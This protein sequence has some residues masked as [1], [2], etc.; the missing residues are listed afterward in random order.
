MAAMPHAPKP[1]PPVSRLH[2]Q[3]IYDPQTG[4]I[5]SRTSRTSRRAGKRCDRHRSGYLCV[6]ID[7]QLHLAHRIAW[8]MHYGEPPIGFIDHKNRD[9][10]DNRIE[11]LRDC[12]HPENMWN[13]KV[14]SDSSTG[15]KGLSFDGRRQRWRGEITVN[16]KRHMLPRRKTK[17]AALLDLTDAR[18]RLHAEFARD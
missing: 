12:S 17:E 3:F 14:R 6:Y 16:G 4:F 5:L 8:I 10:I 18:K 13:A 9:K 15:I 7:G 1:L 11:N 2:E